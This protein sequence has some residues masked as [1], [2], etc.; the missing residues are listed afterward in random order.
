[1]ETE[2]EQDAREARVD[3]L[4]D[5]YMA[6]KNQV[7]L[8][9]EDAETL[10]YVAGFI[11]DANRNKGSL[12]TSH[13]EAVRRGAM[14]GINGSVLHTMIDI[15]KADDLEDHPVISENDQKDAAEIQR[16]SD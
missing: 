3:N 2:Q 4:V 12:D 16:H 5:D 7:L 9:L 15:A 13:Y 14:Q 10:D 1:M 6:D 8:A 11:A